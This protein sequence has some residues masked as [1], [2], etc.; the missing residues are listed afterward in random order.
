MTKTSAA[1]DVFA[2][3]RDIPPPVR[4]FSNEVPQFDA[5]SGFS[6]FPA[7]CGAAI[8]SNFGHTS[9]M[10]ITKE[11]A[12][13][14]RG[15]IEKV[16]KACKVSRKGMVVAIL[17][18]NQESAG[19]REVFEDCGFERLYA[20]TNPNHDNTTRLFLYAKNIAPGNINYEHGT[21]VFKGPKEDS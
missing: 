5:N 10:K 17:N 6:G 13:I 20:T 21:G 18:H 3:L 8:M 16:E 1:L 4:R 11:Y 15:N 14:L 2:L 9:G 12:K 19:L 7:C